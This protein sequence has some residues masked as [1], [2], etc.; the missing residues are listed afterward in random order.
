M[1]ATLYLIHGYI[2]SGKMTYAKKLE[3]ETDA[4]RFTL[5]E[6]MVNF[7]GAN[8]PANKFAE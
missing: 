8:P 4:I 7:Y 6:W 5:D 3:A 2:A 1:T